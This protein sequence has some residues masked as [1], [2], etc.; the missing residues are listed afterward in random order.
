M[1]KRVGIIEGVTVIVGGMLRHVP[2]FSLCAVVGEKVFSM[3]DCVEIF[4]KV[5]YLQH[6][7]DTGCMEEGS[8]VLE[9]VAE[10]RS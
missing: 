4:A 5:P 2:L 7:Y 10:V 8:S 3:V 6:Y 9:R 1:I